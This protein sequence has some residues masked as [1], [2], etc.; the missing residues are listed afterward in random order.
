MKYIPYFFLLTVIF[1]IAIISCNKDDDSNINQDDT[2]VKKY[3]WAVGM[4]DST[5]YG[6]ILF[7]DDG[8][9]KW[10][11][12]GED[13]DVL[14]GVTLNDVYAVDENTVWT[15]GNNNTILKTTDGGNN[16]VR[17]TPPT[18]F[19]SAG[20]AAISLAGSDNIWISGSQGVVYNST[21]GGISW[22][23][24]DAGFFHHGLMQGIH[25]V[26][27]DVVYVAGSYSPGKVNEKGFIA[28][29]T[30]G[31]Q[32]W[33]SIVPQNNFNRNLWIGVTS[34]DAENIIIY[35]VKSHYMHTNDGGQTWYN[36]SLLN[37]GGTNGADINCLKMLNPQTWWGA[38][39]YDGIYLT[40]DN[41]ISWIKQTSPPP[42]GMWLIG[43]DYYNSDL[44]VIVGVETSSLSGKIIQT[45]DGGNHWELKQT[46]DTW[47]NKVSYIK[48]R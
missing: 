35:G 48:N 44:A 42:L 31:G 4:Q 37:T 46:W 3:V 14:K 27:S 7:S 36:D 10:V 29:T 6:L 28:V 2:A 21:N 8:G 24:F 1:I 38:F 40:Q 11:R 23:V 18:G 22:T 15:V 45:T 20:L 41:G 34:A 5:G 47:I 39:D 32:S 26:N 13:S 30:D 19:S 16:W 9:N 25:A 17:V 12:Q 43:L 33:D